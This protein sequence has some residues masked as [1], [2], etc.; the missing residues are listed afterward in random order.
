MVA[1]FHPALAEKE[2]SVKDGI[3]GGAEVAVT[4]IV[5]ELVAP[6][7][8]LNVS[9]IVY[10]PFGKVIGKGVR[11]LEVVEL[12]AVPLLVVKVQFTFVFD[13]ILLPVEMKVNKTLE[14]A[15]TVN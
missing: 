3:L 12:K 2:E 4:F 10:V 14:P 1:L 5:F 11:R 7:G 15:Q 8:S 9:V 13:E 6:L